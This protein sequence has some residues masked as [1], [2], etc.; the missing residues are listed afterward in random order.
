MKEKI[1][2]LIVFFHTFYFTSCTLKEDFDECLIE[3]E[4]NR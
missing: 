4:N 3:A 1:I 2:K